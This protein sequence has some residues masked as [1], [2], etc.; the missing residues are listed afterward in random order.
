VSAHCVARAES[1]LFSLPGVKR[2]I[3]EAQVEG[4]LN[5]SY[6]VAALNS[7][8]TWRSKTFQRIWPIGDY[9]EIQI[10]HR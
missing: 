8:W 2:N 9:C 6:N 10:D 1:R 3:L 5:V 4:E 7:F